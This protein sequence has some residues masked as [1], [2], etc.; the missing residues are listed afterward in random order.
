MGWA[1]SLFVI[2]VIIVKHNS[3]SLIFTA[4][5]GS[6]KMGR[7]VCLFVVDDVVIVI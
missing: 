5:E 3:A 1:V 6:L 7:R 2:A 4:W